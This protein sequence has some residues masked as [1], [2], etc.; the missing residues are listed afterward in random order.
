MPARS[1]S[2][3]RAP[4]S[5]RSASSPAA[6]VA[7]TVVWIP[8]APRVRVEGHA[9]AELLRSVTGKHQVGVAVHE[10]REQRA[11]G[12]VDPVLRAAQGRVTGGCD[13]GERVTVDEE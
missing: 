10:P 4:A 3:R 6:R 2:A 7:S 12:G 1:A 11:A 13:R 9:G 8:P 5:A